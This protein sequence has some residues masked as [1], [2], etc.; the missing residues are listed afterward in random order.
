MEDISC[1]FYLV[2]EFIDHVLSNEGRVLVH[3]QQ[4]VSRSSAM[5]ISYLM[6]KQDT[7]FSTT[8]IAVKKIRG[9]CSPNPGFITQLMRHYN[10]MHEAPIKPR[11]YRVI[12]HSAASPNL[13]VLKSTNKFPSPACLDSRGSHLLITPDHVYVWLGFECHDSLKEAA[14][15]YVKRV[16]TYG[17]APPSTKIIVQGK[18]PA[19]FVSFF[20]D[21]SQKVT[22]IG[23]NPEYDEEYALL[24]SSE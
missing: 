18:E 11:L 14:H 21:S 16:Q 4:G 8:H 20:D 3:C 2:L 13:L 7:D 5:L 1:L 23:R 12:P 17:K 10:I 19:E 24:Y 9:V 15:A 6:W 22:T